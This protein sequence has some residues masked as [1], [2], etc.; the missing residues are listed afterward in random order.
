MLPTFP[1]TF[2]SNA[3]DRSLGCINSFGFPPGLGILQLETLP[4]HCVSVLGAVHAFLPV[5]L[6][7]Q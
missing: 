7:W 4:R 2:L 6:W 5:C 1:F 3:V